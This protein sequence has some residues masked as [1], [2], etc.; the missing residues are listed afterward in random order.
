M[1]ETYLKKHKQQS[2]N[3]QQD[4]RT[5]ILKKEVKFVTGFP[6]HTSNCQSESR[7]M[8]NKIKGKNPFSP[9]GLVKYPHKF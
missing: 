9:E 1:R 6:F 2:P 5:F 4:K 8:T 7:S 3:L